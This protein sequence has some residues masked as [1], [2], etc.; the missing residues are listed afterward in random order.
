MTIHRRR[1]L[2]AVPAALA[3][4]ATLCALALPRLAAAQD[5]P[6]IRILEKGEA[7]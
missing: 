4:L 2:R 6:V 7:T 3:A 5:K 1:A